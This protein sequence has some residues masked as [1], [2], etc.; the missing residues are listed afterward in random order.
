MLICTLIIMIVKK[1]LKFDFQLLKENIKLE[2][3]T[4]QTT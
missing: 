3:L 4:A 1:D 2:Y